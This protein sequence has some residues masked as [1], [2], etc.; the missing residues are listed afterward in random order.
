MAVAIPIVA[1]LSPRDLWAPDEPRYGRIAYNMERGGDWL[2]SRWNGELDAEKPPL[3]YWI[4]AAG[5]RVTGEVDARASRVPCALLAALAVLATAA[6]GRRWFRDAALADTAAL[7]FS[8]MG[9]VLWNSSR[10]GLD[11]PLTAWV[12]LATWAGSALVDRPSVRAAVGMGAAIG[13]GVLF[14]GPHALYVPVGAVVGGC[15]AS[16]QG[17]RLR[18]PRWLLVVGTIVALV[19]AWLVPV[20]LWGGPEFSERMLGQLQSRVSGRDEPHLHAFPYL[21]GLVLACGLPWTPAWLAGL[22]TALR[23]RRAP[24]EHRFGLGAAAGGTLVALILL[25]LA[26]SKR[27]VYLIPLLP[28]LA[29]LAAYVLH[30]HPGSRPARDS[31]SW[32]PL[33]LA[34]IALAA[35]AAPLALPHLLPKG[36][37][38]AVFAEDVQGGRA[39]YVFVAIGL[40]L[41]VAAVLAFRRRRTPSAAARTTGLALGGAWVACALWL[42]PVLDDVS[43][44]KAALAPLR[45]AAVDARLVQLG[46]P[47]ALLVWAIRPA[48]VELLA[49]DTSTIPQTLDELYAEG[50]P[51]AVTILDVKYWEAAQAAIP[52]LATRAEVLW[53]R[54]VSHR[55]WTVLVPRR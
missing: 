32:F 39:P 51:R 21:L 17:R 10:A 24:A 53:S 20:L 16:G 48:E 41:A 19:A 8:A 11:L 26:A 13:L 12:L 45:A 50:A 9:L 54:R 34:G 55:R 27:D 52:S 5:G 28:C 33:C 14:K 35:L 31:A 44:W 36:P 3:G 37:G 49:A 30:R 29:L 23:A 7:L 46:A 15:L 40:G 47:D 4:M 25:S 22:W 38:E 42:L 6:L 43:T 18:D 1:A 2:V